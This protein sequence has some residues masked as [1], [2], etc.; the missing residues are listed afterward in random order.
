MDAINDYNKTLMTLAAGTVALSATFLG[1]SLYHGVALN[2]LYAAWSALA[3]C[4]FLGAVLFGKYISDL[5]ESVD[6]KPRQG[7]MEVLSF[8]QFLL[9]LAG[10][11]CLGVFAIQNATH[12]V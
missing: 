7:S 3:L 6:P 12:H 10:F 11:A 2:W 4:V 8:F 9:L 5:A 1:Q